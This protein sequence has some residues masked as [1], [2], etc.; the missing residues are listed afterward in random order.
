MSRRRG[1]LATL[2]A[3]VVLLFA[4][5]WIASF[6]AASW[7][8]G[9][10]SP[11]ARAFLSGVQL[12]RLTIDGAAV[13]LA[14]A[15]FIGHLIVVVRAVGSVQ[16]PRHVA[17]IEFREAVRGDFL[18]AGAVG[19]GLVL[20]LLLGLD[21]S[22]HWPTFVLAWH[23]V[24]TGAVEPLLGRD[25]G[26]YLAQLPLWRVAH[27]FAFL[28][29]VVATALVAT[30]YGVIG[31]IRVDRRRLAI[32]DHARAHLG[33]L[34]AALALCLAWGYA[35]E[36]FELVASF[37]GA[38]TGGEFRRV[39]V[40][41]PA[42]TG[43]ALMVAALS[44]L[45]TVRPRHA[46]AAAAWAILVLASV[47]GHHVAP[48]ILRGDIAPA[49]ADS[50]R[51]EMESFAFG[52]EGIRQDEGPAL[53][54]APFFDAD[55]A[56]RI[57]AVQEEVATIDAGAIVSGGTQQPSWL[58]LTGTRDAPAR[59]VAVAADRASS[60]GGPLF[61]RPGDTLAYPSPYAA[62]TLSQGAV[63]PG[64]PRYF[65]GDIGHGVPVGSV[66]RRLALAWA[67]QA[68]ELL[69]PA[70]GTLRI[71]WA[72]SPG[73]R[74]ATLAPF[75]SWSGVRARVVNGNAL[76]IADGYVVE[77]GYP[78][79]EPARWRGGR[80][81]FVRAA[82]LGVVN[83]STGSARVFLRDEA[84]PVAVAWAEISDGVVESSSALAPMVGQAAGYPPELFALQAEVLGARADGPGRPAVP[85]PGA[86]LVQ[87]GWDS[88]GADVLL[89]PFH[90]G[91]GSR[92]TALLSATGGTAPVLSPV[93]NGLL[94]ARALERRWARFAT[95]APIQDSVVGAGAELQV[96]D[97]QYWSTPE[98]LGALQ[99]HTAA[100]PGAR[101]A[102][103]WVT[104]ATGRRLGAGRSFTEA[105][106]N[107]QGTAASAPPGST[108]G[109]L[110]EARHW[111]RLADE[112]LRRSDWAAF[113][114]AFDALR[115]VLHPE[116]E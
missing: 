25:T 35:L 113:G 71:D 79:V 116:G 72:L 41:A 55:A 76:W 51:R 54:A 59:L 50:V 83:A 58:V 13:L 44:A 30:L 21:A 32:N 98:G 92:V 6:L 77:A 46:L 62:V 115:R 24:R 66:A 57:F 16:I 49:A 93:E 20:G 61:Y 112:A 8:A 26:V 70:P 14:A 84:D 102:I 28:L 108:Q 99:V 52:L 37:D 106:D 45:W 53:I 68:R 78:L 43:V 17:N 38:P 56:R 48:L 22:A 94:A 29:V 89:V 97:V 27:Q 3:A 105:W 34:L 39:S 100:R 15:W 9:Q 63:R 23:G 91:D 19:T 88:G 95:F 33:L 1:L 86:P 11:A 42:L 107:L 109:A 73:Q 67:L 5:R 36:P 82:F 69:G 101:P 64:A 4:G 104:V 10:F 65:V 87:S 47:G 2:A 31:A 111:M 114:R 110:A 80:A 96:S 85:R 12:L 81:G 18:L 90:G 40:I 7:W 103:V 74:L 75:A 60:T